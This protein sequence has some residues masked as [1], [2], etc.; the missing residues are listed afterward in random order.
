M[1]D[2][3]TIRFE[4]EHAGLHEHELDSDPFAQFGQWLQAAM[5]HDKEL[6]NAMV[7]A[8][9]DRDG[10]PSA[11]YVLLKEFSNEG[12]VFYTNSLSQK[13]RELAENPRAALVFYW[14]QMH[15]QIRIEGNVEQLS[16]D[17]AD[18]YFASRPRGSQI[19]T[20]A[21][22]Q[23]GIVPDRNFLQDRVTELSQQFENKTVPRPEDWVGYCVKPDTFEF[24]QGQENR[25]HDRLVYLRNETG[26]W[27]I[28]RLA[29]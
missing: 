24:W 6:A 1:S 21:A 13:G 27:T 25:L 14:R 29:P 19:S 22:P 26:M 16:A 2:L 5:A 28:A 15:R 20:W 7:L 18:S 8:T 23:S 10:R 3:S 11:R 17:R 9:A 4:Y 12:F